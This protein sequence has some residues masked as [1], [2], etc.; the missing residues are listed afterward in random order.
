MNF[1]LQ[2][3]TTQNVTDYIT[4][5]Y[6]MFISRDIISKLWKGEIPLSNEIHSTVE[7]INMT[8]NTKLRTVRATKFTK[9]E[10]EFLKTTTGSL[11]ERSIV[12]TRKF[13][14]TIT[15]AYISKLDKK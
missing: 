1:K 15:K 5:H 10:L 8:N 11:L 2:D 13:G 12:F 3:K 7:Y 9:E 6:K 4:E 14:K